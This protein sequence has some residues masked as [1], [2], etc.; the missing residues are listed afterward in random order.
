MI[1]VQQDM[2]ILKYV[3]VRVVLPNMGHHNNQDDDNLHLDE[4]DISH[5]NPYPHSQ[6]LID[7]KEKQVP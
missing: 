6:H 3:T 4:S 5:H 2:V 1:A 7:A